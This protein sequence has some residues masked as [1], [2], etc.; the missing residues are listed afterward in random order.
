MRTVPATADSRRG[1]SAPKPCWGNGGERENP[2]S[3]R[4]IVRINVYAEELTGEVK[5][6]KT[7]ADT[8]REQTGLRFFQ[9]SPASLHAT[10][11][12]DDRTAVT[13][14]LHRKGS[15]G[16]ATFRAALVDAI[17]LIDGDS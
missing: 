3:R 15:E 17:L 12:D 4:I 9:E 10:A 6:V 7:V 8:G 14:W 2:D 5:I 1:G 11:E 13:F 16:R